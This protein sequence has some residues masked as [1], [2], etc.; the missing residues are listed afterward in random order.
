MNFCRIKHQSENSCLFVITITN[1]K[2]TALLDHVVDSLAKVHVGNNPTKQPLFHLAW[3]V[4]KHVIEA[5]EG[6]YI[7]QHFNVFEIFFPIC[8][9][10]LKEA[11]FLNSPNVTNAA[12]L[13][14]L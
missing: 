10:Y 11:I 7:F 12:I 13:S 14:A 5:S 8:Y 6:N 4:V 3:N 1:D 9:L 2:A